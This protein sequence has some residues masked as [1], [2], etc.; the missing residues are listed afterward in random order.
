MICD[1]ML[2]TKACFVLVEM[3]ILLPKHLADCLQVVGLGGGKEKI[4]L[5]SGLRFEYCH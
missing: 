3:S 5:D 4:H 2:R 1:E